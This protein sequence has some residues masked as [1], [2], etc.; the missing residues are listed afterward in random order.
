[1]GEFH[2]A[3]ALRDVD[4]RRQQV[5]SGG[6]LVPV[7]TA[8]IAVLAALATLFA[9]HSSTLALA[10]KNEG[11]LLQAKAADQ[12]NWY[13]AKQ[14]KVQVGQTLL[15]SGIVPS[16]TGRQTLEKRIKSEMQNSDAVRDKAKSLEND[17]NDAM[18]RSDRYMTSYENYQISATLFEVSVVLVSITALMRTRIFLLIA[19]GAT[20][21]GLAFLGVGL[22]H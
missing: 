4:E 11:V 8:V 17:S 7:L 21:V 19:G 2:A 9:H 3:R 22:S 15:D 13:Q 6:K 10:K 20:A 12:Y 18:E 16:A 5:A 1:M 14:I